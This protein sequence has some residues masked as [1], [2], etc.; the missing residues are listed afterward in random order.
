MKRYKI[1]EMRTARYKMMWFATVEDVQRSQDV[2]TTNWRKMTTMSTPHA[3][4]QEKAF[5]RALARA[6]AT[7][8]A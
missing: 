1:G 7:G 6:E 4:A 2:R 8:R 3:R 5:A